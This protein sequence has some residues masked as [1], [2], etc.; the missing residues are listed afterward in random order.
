MA[1]KKYEQTIADAKLEDVHIIWRNFSGEERLPYNK[2]GDRNFSIVLDPTT[3][4]AM[5]RDGWNVKFRQPKEEDGD[6]L[7]HLPVKVGYSG[8]PPAIYLITSRGRNILTEDT[9]STLDYADI[10]KVDVIPHPY[11]WDVSGNQGVK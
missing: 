10:Q 6:I 7:I 11:E 2:K 9:I 1:Q 5:K 4:E 3:A 8:R